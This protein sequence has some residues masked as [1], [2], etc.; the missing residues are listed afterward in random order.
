MELVI[1]RHLHLNVIGKGGGLCNAQW[2]ANA[3]KDAARPVTGAELVHGH[4]YEAAEPESKDTGGL[5]L[6]APDLPVIS[7][8]GHQPA[9]QGG[10]GAIGQDATLS[11]GEVVRGHAPAPQELMW[12]ENSAGLDDAHPAR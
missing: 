2:E 12:I 7:R 5:V 1:G 11:R 4:R 8:I 10:A 6:D 3:R 9:D